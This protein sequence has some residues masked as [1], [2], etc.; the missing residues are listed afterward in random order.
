MTYA[1]RYCRKKNIPYYIFTHGQLSRWSLSVSRVRKAIYYFLFLRRDLSAAKAV[2]FMRQDE[3]RF[4]K[5]FKVNKILF[6]NALD[7][8]AITAPKEEAL[9]GE[10]RKVKDMAKLL[11]LSRIHPKK[12]LLLVVRSLSEIV[13][14]YPYVK[15]TVAGPVEDRRYFEK[16]LSFIRSK[17]LENNIIF[18]GLV[19]GEEKQRILN[20]SGIFLLPTKDD[21]APLA[22]LEA[23]AA[24]LP[25]ITTKGADIPEIDRQMGFIVKEDPLDI[26]N[27][28][29]RI[30][31]DGNLAL[32]M[33]K[34][35]QEY[36]LNEFTW[37]KRAKELELEL[38]Q[39]L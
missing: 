36:V 3:L 31:S 7:T 25:V 1:A 28:V 38:K 17:G 35:G 12:G 4:L 26:S 21:C 18:K 20:E 24:G 39:Y 13:K 10:E 33:S 16:V 23:L 19:D 14:K 22:I 8:S 2:F 30:I 5:E 32:H 34:R 29:I 37:S 27:A 15:L 9:L 6:R 11:Y